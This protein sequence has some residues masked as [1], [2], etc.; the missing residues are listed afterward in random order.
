MLK[1]KNYLNFFII[2]SIFYSCS[3]YQKVLRSTD[4]DYKFEKAV[5]YYNDGDFNR[6]M[7]IFNE[8]STVLK[9]TSKIH[10]VSYYYAYCNYGIGDN[11][12]AAY[13]FR[14]YTR[15]FPNSK[16]TEECAYMTAFCYYNEAPDYSLDP[17]NV[18]MAIKELQ[19][20]INRYPDSD[21]VIECNSLIDE[22][23]N[24]LSKKAFENAKQ[25]YLTSNYK[26]AIIALDNVL[27]DFPSFDNREEVHFLLINATYDLAV[28]SIS[29][30]VEERLNQSL[31]AYY[32]FKDNYPDSRYLTQLEITYNKAKEKLTNLKNK[33]NEI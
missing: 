18:Y 23:R 4:Y 2:V 14:D 29:S 9:G 22:L 12:M 33:K 10:E 20:F 11:L 19:S 16:H 31:D 6:A 25:Y 27:I 32:H 15:S 26:S 30:K 7:P 8:L 28:N 1:M 13:L 21:K 24:R 3:K 5:S 17:T